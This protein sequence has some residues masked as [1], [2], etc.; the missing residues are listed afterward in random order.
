MSNKNNSNH[1][2]IE[3]EDETK[4]SKKQN[5]EIQNENIAEIELPRKIVQNQFF[6][7][8][9][10]LQEI[11]KT[12]LSQAKKNNEI[13][14]E[15]KAIDTKIRLLLKEGTFTRTNPVYKAL[16]SQFQTKDP[17]G[18]F[19]KYTNLFFLLYFEPH[20]LARI[21]S[22]LSAIEFEKILPIIMTSIYGNSYKDQEEKLLQLL[23]SMALHTEFKS[24]TSAQTLL[25]S[26]STVSK[27]LV[28]YSQRQP[29][30][31]YVK[32]IL[33]SFLTEIANNQDLDLEVNPVHIYKNLIA[34][35]GEDAP[36][37]TYESLKSNTQVMEIVGSHVDQLQAWFDQ[38]FN[39]I[40]KNVDLIPYGIRLI[41][42]KIR[43]L[44]IEFFP[45]FSRYRIA[46]FIGGFLIL[47]LIN[48]VVITPKIFDIIPG[49]YA[50]NPKRNA[51]LLAKLLQNVANMTNIDTEKEEYMS[52]FKDFV[53]SKQEALV[54][55]LETVCQVTEP[56]DDEELSKFLNMANETTEISI[57]ISQIYYMHS[58]FKEKLF[59]VV[60]TVDDPLSLLLEMLGKEVPQISSND[61]KVIQVP[62]RNSILI[63]I[64]KTQG[65][66]FVIYRQTKLQIATVYQKIQSR[67]EKFDYDPKTFLKLIVKLRN[68]A[69]KKGN[70]KENNKLKKI[71][72]NLKILVREK[73]ISPDD[74][75]YKL[76][77]EVKEIL[78][79]IHLSHKTL[80][81]E[82]AVLE[83][84]KSNL[85]KE[86]FEFSE[87]L[88]FYKQYLIKMRNT[89]YDP[90]NFPK[91]KN[92]K[93]QLTFSHEEFEH[94]GILLE[95]SFPEERKS[96][97]LFVLAP[98][99]SFGVFSLFVQVASEKKIL[100]EI[101][102]EIETLLDAEQKNDRKLDIGGYL[103]LDSSFLLNTIKH[104]F[105]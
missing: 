61:D 5:Q 43:D 87:N 14:K 18:N 103:I 1:L 44:S 34:Q 40:I 21:S 62:L 92:K 93:T 4:I 95:S 73:F 58:L 45:D 94:S 33:S 16:F 91:R 31:I 39:S 36:K 25:R 99:S 52:V 13:E 65:E 90:S 26:N 69:K 74:K 29:G 11:K 9:E 24:C 3:L 15:L 83:R 57:S 35:D 60:D 42:R 88:K 50:K 2:K 37:A 56:D 8:V 97:L 76:H 72:S 46:G 6:K 22:V 27:L 66:L 23:F 105:L 67:I 7:D 28:Q 47:R 89:V 71:L 30:Q 78:E 68:I 102:I 104:T 80:S 98:S 70:K 75:F 63:S 53:K 79:N 77:Q 100:D 85:E 64:E 17:I 84:V 20:Y 10:Y 12:I 51:I 49:D 96:S 41:C 38:L 86:F 54:D 48:P 82:I 59:E 81:T 32:K 101:Q 55:F 19:E